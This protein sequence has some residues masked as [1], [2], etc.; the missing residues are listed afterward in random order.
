LEHSSSP[1]EFISKRFIA[2]FASVFA[3]PG[4]I[5]I[6]SRREAGVYLR[7][8][9][10]MLIDRRGHVHPGH[11]VSI[12]D[13]RRRSLRTARS[14]LDQKREHV[15]RSVTIAGRRFASAGNLP[16]GHCANMGYRPEI[17]DYLRNVPAML[18]PNSIGLDL[19]RC[20]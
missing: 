19:K 5:N 16:G 11:R 12:T 15:L 10:A 8:V 13:L 14:H 9:A 3:S 2:A 17:A 7:N 6:A 4:C 20:V 18:K 1:F